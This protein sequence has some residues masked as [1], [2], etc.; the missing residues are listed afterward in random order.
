MLD[1][2]KELRDGNHLAFE[3]LFDNSYEALCR[4]AYSILRDM[5]DAEDVVQKVFCKLW[6]Q[7]EELNIQSS[8]NSYLYRIVHNDSLNN[9]HQKTSH[10]EHNL[11]YVSMMNADVNSTIEHIESS[12]LQKA[13]D[14]ALATLPPQCKKVFE[15]SRIEQLSYSEIAAQLNISTNTVENHI[16][17]ALK[18]L[19]IELK[20]FLSICLLLQLLKL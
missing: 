9:I 16:S 19:R 11:N 5:D 18:L 10:Q 14:N 8:V 7:R 4:Y 12:D 17:K 3:Q 13:I 6:D 20:E 1:T 2:I 15:M